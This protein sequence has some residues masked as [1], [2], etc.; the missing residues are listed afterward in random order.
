M[1]CIKNNTKEWTIYDAKMRQFIYLTHEEFKQFLLDRPVKLVGRFIKVNS[2]ERIWV[3]GLL[4]SEW[5]K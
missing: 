5:F 3:D 1:T 4:N 2:R